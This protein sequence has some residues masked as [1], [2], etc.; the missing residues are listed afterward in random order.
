MLQN[1][2]GVPP[3]CTRSGGHQ[4]SA[5]PPLRN[6][7]DR[8]HSLLHRLG[9]W[10]YAGLFALIALTL[11]LHL[12][13]INRPNEWVFDESYYVPDAAVNVSEGHGTNFPEHPPLGKL[14]I[15]LGIQLFGNDPFGWRFFPVVFGIACVALLYLICRRLGISKDMSLFAASLLAFENLTFVQ[16]A[17]AMLDIFSVAFMMLSFWLYLRGSYGGAG[18]SA[19]LAAL[20]KLTGALALPVICLHWLMTNRSDWKRFVPSMLAAPA[21]FLLLLPVFDYIVWREFLNP[22]SQVSTMLDETTARTFAG[23]TSPGDLSRSWDWIVKPEILTYWPNTEY[24]DRMG[25]PGWL[26]P[27]YVAM[28]S[29]TVWALTIPTLAFLAYATR[30]ACSAAAFSLAWFA[31]TFLFWVGINLLTDRITYIFYFFPTMGALCMGIALGAGWMRGQSAAK[32]PRWRSNSLRALLPLYLLGHLVAFAVLS[33]VS[34]WW[35][36]PGCILAYVLLRSEL[37]RRESNAHQGQIHS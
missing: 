8:V 33:P 25:E 27:R 23:A 24:V 15:A 5:Q 7:F 19:G 14:F 1:I 30:K 18:V 28:I 12:S 26:D 29:P 37:S 4:L 34:Y 36:L 20:A 6:G 9:N 11:T 3:P 32:G 2:Q 16:S 35:K 21:S 13:T 31:G 10:E 22:F 17:I